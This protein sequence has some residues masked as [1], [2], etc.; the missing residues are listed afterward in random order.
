MKFYSADTTERSN[1]SYQGKLIDIVKEI[2]RYREVFKTNPKY[3]IISSSDF[4]MVLNE[5]NQVGILPNRFRE[6]EFIFYDIPIILSLDF[7]KGF[8]DVVGN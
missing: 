3:I 4:E 8:Y 1:L 7:N 5:M 2:R 6:D